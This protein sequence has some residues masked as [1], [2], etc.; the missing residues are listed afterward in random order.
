MGY[1]LAGFDVVGVDKDPQPGY[2]FD[3]VR[4]DAI[5]LA[6]D[7][8]F[9]AQFD[10]KAGSPPCQLFTNC[11]KIR[12]NDHPNL[13]PGMREAFQRDGKPW[14]IENVVGA[15]LID[16]VMLC[17]VM[18][19]GL[20]TYRHRL[21]EASFTI[22]LPANTDPDDRE[23]C[24]RR[25][26]YRTTKM[27]RAPQ[28]GEF[29]HVVGNFSGAQQGREAMGI[30]WMPREKLREAIPPAYTEWIGRQLLAQ[31]E[32][33]QRPEWVQVDLFAELAS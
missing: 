1:H 6:N 17:G 11:Q 27:G 30:D 5:A 12:G 25:H 32:A 9:M 3:F 23:D 10:A 21:F 20:R 28:P 22:S 13:V 29:M 7:P 2:P 4:G 26:P 19:P 33:P 31:V 24:G 16:P 15:P 8:G 18:F 14:V